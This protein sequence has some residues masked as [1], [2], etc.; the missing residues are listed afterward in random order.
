MCLIECYFSFVIQ[1][2]NCDITH[3]D[4]IHCEVFYWNVTV[5]ANT[6]IREKNV[7]VIQEINCN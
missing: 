2:I 1:S 6:D 5:V 4:V 7:G 3:I